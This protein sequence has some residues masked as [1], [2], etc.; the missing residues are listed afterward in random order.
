MGPALSQGKVNLTDPIWEAPVAPRPMWVQ[1]LKE[2]KSLSM[3]T[4][5]FRVL[6]L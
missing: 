1:E 5:N 2:L 3:K 6:S 4:F